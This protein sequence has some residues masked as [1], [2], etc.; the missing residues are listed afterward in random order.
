M[1]CW[2][3]ISWITDLICPEHYFSR[4]NPT[5]KLPKQKREEYLT[6]PNIYTV[7]VTV[8]INNKKIPQQQQLHFQQG[9]L[10]MLN[11]PSSHPL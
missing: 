7:N 11:K 2:P 1:S 6:K 8:K 10:N 4:R 9:S 3:S 5:M